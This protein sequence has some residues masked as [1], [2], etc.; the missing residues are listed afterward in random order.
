MMRFFCL[1]FILS[2]SVASAQVH[3][4]EKVYKNAN[5]AVVRI[6]TS[7]RNNKLVGQGSGVILKSK[8]WIVTNAHVAGTGNYLFAEHQGTLF[9]LDSIIVKDTEADILVIRIRE[10]DGTDALEDIPDLKVFD[11]DKVKTGQRIYTIG[12]PLDFENTI[13]EGIISGIRRSG[14]DSLSTYLQISA[15][16]SEGSSGGAVLDAKGRLIGITT[17]VVT[18]HVVQNINFAIPINKV[19]EVVEQSRVVDDDPLLY[20]RYYKKAF[21]EME[22]HHYDHALSYFRK[23]AGLNHGDE[24]DKNNLRYMIGRCYLNISETDSA[25]TYLQSAISPP[26]KKY[27]YYYL[28]K[29]WIQKRNYKNA[30][31]AFRNSIHADNNFVDAYNGMALLYIKQHQLLKASEWLLRAAKVE[32][33]N[34]ETIYLT[35]KAFYISG[36]YDD[37]IETLTDLIKWKPYYADAI[38]LLAEIYMEKGETD[39]SFILQQRA[40]KLKPELR[41]GRLE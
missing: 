39:K 12:S 37:A 8:R 20:D 19:F 17:S 21:E 14:H 23:A 15:P 27:C 29:A 5:D 7:G 3:L 16:I 26:I 10:M 38:Y 1:L 33:A 35:A 2:S 31:I 18:G 40:F 28:G 24:N 6:Y 36:K 25:I 32:R 30:E 9:E 22:I 13:S 11:S 34:P 4:A 41:N